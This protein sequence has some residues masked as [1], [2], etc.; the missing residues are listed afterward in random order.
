MKNKITLLAAMVMLLFACKKESGTKPP[1]NAATP[2]KSYAIGFNVSGFSESST[3]LTTNAV[4]AKT[5]AALKD[6]IKF[7]YYF[8]FTRDENGTYTEVSKGVQKAADA[9]FGTIKDTLEAG[10]YSVYFVG[11]QAPGHYEFKFETSAIYADPIFYYDDKSVYETFHNAMQ[12]DVSGTSTQAIVLKRVV[13]EISVKVTDPLPANAK[14]LRLS[15]GDYPQGLDLNMGVGEARPHSQFEFRDTA[16]VSFPIS[17]ANVG[18]AGFTV[19]K[20]VWQSAYFGIVVDCLDASGKVIAT[21]TLPKNLVDIYTQLLNN[22]HYT[23]SGVLFGNT[24]SFSVSLDDKWNT[25]V[26]STFTLVPVKKN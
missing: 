12:L 22:T 18:K 16:K 25:P 24:N 7:L 21:K 17:V 10:H 14:T 2:K 13:A 5:T 19:D 11:T 20:Y 8:I 3:S 26:N 23:Y 1:T 4:N 15:F 9:N 6:Q